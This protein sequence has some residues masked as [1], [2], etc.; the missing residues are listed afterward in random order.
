MKRFNGKSFL[1]GLI[2]GTLV[3]SS[4]VIAFAAS[5]TTDLKATYRDIKVFV[6]ENQIDYTASNGAYAEPFIIDG[7]TYIP[8]RLF[9]E[10]LGQ[11]VLW[12]DS[13][14]SIYIGQ[15]DQHDED[16]TAVLEIKEKVFKYA[17]ENQ[18]YPS[19]EEF[20]YER[21]LGDAQVLL[22]AEEAYIIGIPVCPVNI[23]TGEQESGAVDFYWYKKSTGEI[24]YIGGGQDWQDDWVDIN[25]GEWT[26]PSNVPE[27][28]D[29]IK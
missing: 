24:K 29:M 19:D 17:I 25:T 7:T 5:Y 12:D 26:G 4:I 27:G 22:D 1:M 10:K 13:T 11:Q 16:S 21:S 23:Q 9:S 3:C 18:N 20:K 15:H 14:S 8:L 2:V 6:D 28:L